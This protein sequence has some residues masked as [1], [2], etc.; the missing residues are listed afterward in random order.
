MGERRRRQE[1]RWSQVIDPGLQ[2]ERTALAWERTAIAV[3]I[4]GVLLSRYAAQS[5]HWT[6]AL[7]GLLQ[8]SI[9]GGLLVWAGMHYTELQGP[10]QDGSDVV[11]PTAT[12]IVG[13]STVAFS[14]VALLLAT[15]E[16]ATR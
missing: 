15:L 13:L 10:L 8:T 11:H 2:Q 1:R 6:T 12:R 14:G 4:S 3:M 7:A 5:A 16:I 9:G